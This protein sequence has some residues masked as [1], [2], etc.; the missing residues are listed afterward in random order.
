M[1]DQYD[2]LSESDS[3]FSA[4]TTPNLSSNSLPVSAPLDR[5]AFDPSVRSRVFDATTAVLDLSAAGNL[6]QRLGNYV[7]YVMRYDD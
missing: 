6:V 1:D 4:G 5:D 3:A 7:M 2:A